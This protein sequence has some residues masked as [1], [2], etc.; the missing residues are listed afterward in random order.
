MREGCSGLVFITGVLCFVLTGNS[1]CRSSGLVGSNWQCATAVDITQNVVCKT[2]CEERKLLFSEYL[3]S[4]KTVAKVS[5]V[6]SLIPFVY[7]PIKR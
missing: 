6:L 5:S 7:T 4:I 3:C 2:R 1:L